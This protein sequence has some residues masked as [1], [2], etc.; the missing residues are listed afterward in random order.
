ML[1]RFSMCSIRSTYKVFR[2]VPGQCKCIDTNLLQHIVG[3]KTGDAIVN[4]FMHGIKLQKYITLK[5]TFNFAYY[6]M[7]HKV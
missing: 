5:P 1:Q 7:S 4:V 3:Q 6:Y 2:M